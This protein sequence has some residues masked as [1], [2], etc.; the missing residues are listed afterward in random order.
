LLLHQWLGHLLRLHLHLLLRLDS[1]AEQGA[2]H[3]DLL[4]RL[5]SSLHHILGLDTDGF[6]LG[7]LLG[8]HGN[9]FHF[10]I[11]GE[12]FAGQLGLLLLLLGCLPLRDHALANVR[13]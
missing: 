10:L 9:I 3:L 8:L 11:F 2:A 12:S 4:L 7:L 5:H 13:I 1:S 6:E